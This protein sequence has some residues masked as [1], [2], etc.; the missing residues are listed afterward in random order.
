MGGIPKKCYPKVQNLKQ[1]NSTSTSPHNHHFPLCQVHVKVLKCPDFVINLYPLQPLCLL[2]VDHIS[3]VSKLSSFASNWNIENIPWYTLQPS[4]IFEA[5][6]FSFVSRQSSVVIYATLVPCH[7]RYKM[8]QFEPNFS[9]LPLHVAKGSLQR[10]T[11]WDIDDLFVKTLLVYNADLW[12]RWERKMLN[13]SKYPSVILSLVRH[14]VATLPLPRFPRE[15]HNFQ[16]LLLL[17]LGNRQH[18]RC[19]GQW[20]QLSFFW[21]V[22]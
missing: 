9:H 5:R 2:G 15:M 1:V 17:L 14:S 11:A 8:S 6:F 10:W 22:R 12:C 20:G 7:I 19:W 21:R 13:I 4:Y 18:E 3:N 16:L